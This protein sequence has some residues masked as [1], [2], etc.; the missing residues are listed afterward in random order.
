VR[1]PIA[2]VAAIA[3]AAAAAGSAHAGGG[4][5]GPTFGYGPY[6]RE[7]RAFLFCRIYDKRP[8][9][10][11]TCL[12]DQALAL[13]VKTHNPAREL[14]RID[15]YAHS[16]GGFLDANCHILMHSV[17]RRYAR[18]IHLTLG[19]LRD[20]L[21]RTNDPGCSAGFGHG[22]IMELGPQIVRMGPQ[23][24]AA[25]CRRASTRYQRYS[26]VHGL[27]HAYMRLFS[28]LVA[29]SLAACTA[30]GPAD[31]AD[32]AQGAFHD[33]WI[34][35]AG[36]DQTHRPSHTT[37]S[38]RKLCGSQ[39]A[40]FVRACWYRA[41]LERPPKRIPTSGRGLI[42]LCHGLDGLQQQACVTGGSVIVSIDPF[43]QLAVC[44][45]LRGADA[46]ACIRGVRVPALASQ[47]LRY[48]MRLIKECADID[49]GAQHD[50]YLWLGK[51]L[52]VIR[53]GA[54]ANQGCGEL[55]YSKT[56]AACLEGARSY[57]GALETFS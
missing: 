41:W 15:R 49:H 22:L 34:A 9:R 24:A 10:Y 46:A 2:A 37:T 36:L 39:H 32:C 42:A 12:S 17:G 1:V 55:V 3:A 7:A 19:R 14:P 54:F 52:N 51:A 31:A 5:N 57:E 47:P 20:Y 11:R 27:G 29:P 23:G 21:P 45:Q 8:A 28:E 56:R 13:V 35:V 25:A 38:P 40:Q 18:H 43:D 30:L 4:A 33:Y 44:K 50:C 6:V 26:C 53:N 48:Q 16:V